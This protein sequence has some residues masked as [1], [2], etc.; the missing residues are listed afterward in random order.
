[1]KKLIE[2]KYIIPLAML[3]LF[4]LVDVLNPPGHAMAGEATTAGALGSL[5]RM[6]RL[7]LI[8][9]NRDPLIVKKKSDAKTSSSLIYP[10]ENE[11]ITIK[12]DESQCLELRFFPARGGRR[13]LMLRGCLPTG[14]SLD[15]GRGI[16][17]W[18]PDACVVGHYRLVF[19]VKEPEGILS[20]QEVDIHILPAKMLDKKI[21]TK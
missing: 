20:R 21:Q 19:T 4:A 15:P 14:S 16:F 2:W 11:L 10:D 12:M 13:E 9:I 8:R 7:R 17:R 6:Q 3:I 5:F 1:M 18:T